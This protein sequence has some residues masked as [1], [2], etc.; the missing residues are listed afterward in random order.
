MGKFETYL[1]EFSKSV[2]LADFLINLLV[3]AVLCTLLQF[4]YVRYGNAVSNRERF[5]NNFLPLGL[6]TML[7]ITIV[8]SSIALSLGLVGALSIVRF[9]AAIK[10]PEELTYLFLTIG[11]GLAAGANQPM[12]AVISF[13][14]IVG[15]LLI[16]KKL[17]KDAP[18]SRSNHMYLNISTDRDDL[19]GISAI[20]TRHFSYVALARM[21]KV[22]AQLEL[23][24]LVKADSIDHLEAAQKELIALS[25]ATAVSMVNQPDL[26][27]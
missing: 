26:V 24:Y 7:I 1:E 5:A 22:A 15:L 23:S 3:A 17:G 19:K 14:F 2:N 4:F 6:T 12:I 25:P 8:K 16:R 21:D 10:D 13:F 27:L 11:V 20:L 9:R 18:V